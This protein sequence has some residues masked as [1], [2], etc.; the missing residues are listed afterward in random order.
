MYSRSTSA[1][2][3]PIPFTTYLST[4]VYLTLLQLET[5]NG[6]LLSQGQS[7][8]PLSQEQNSQLLSQGQSSQLLLQAQNSQLLSQVASSQ[9]LSQAHTSQVLP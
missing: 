4:K 8:Q 3:L 6:Q 9:S 5:E 2:R 1:L 7:S